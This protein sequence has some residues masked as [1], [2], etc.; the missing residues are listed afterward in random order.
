MNKITAV[1]TGGS[2]G[3][4]ASLCKALLEA[5]Y[6]V[7]NMARRPA[8]FQ[9][10]HLHDISV[11]LADRTATAA[12]A[13][14]VARQHEVTVLIHNAGLIRPALLED[15]NIDDLDYLANIHLAAGILLAQAFVP[16]M[17]RAG[18]GRIVNITSRAALGLQTRTCYSATK[19]GM[20][21]M[22]RTW[23]L[24]LAA[25]GITVNA[26]APGPIAATEMFHDVIPDGSAHMQQLAASIPV[27]RLGLPEDVARATL[28]FVAPE[29]DFVTG[30]TLFVCGGSS[31]SSLSI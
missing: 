8:P 19:S 22:T 27:R 13:A 29:N 20:I 4:G 9:H 26:V 11:D 25:Y 10:E 24:E 31:I 15:V 18:R 17:K 3:I 6:A 7:V 14:Q 21:G 5:D 1:V 16:A 28:F 23:A 2:T 30:Q 12:A